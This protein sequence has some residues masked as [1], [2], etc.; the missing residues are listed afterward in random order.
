MEG[1]DWDAM[2]EAAVI[3]HAIWNDP[4]ILRPGELTG[5]TKELH[6]ILSAYGLTYT[7]RLKLRVRIETDNHDSPPPKEEP[8]EVPSNVVP[9]YRKLLGA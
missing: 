4:T 1:T 6:R 9:M 2:L 8:G 5:M 7:D 3:H